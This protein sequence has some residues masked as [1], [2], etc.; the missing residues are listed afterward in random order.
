M[1]KEDTVNARHAL[2]RTHVHT[3]PV[4]QD[5]STTN[6]KKWQLAQ[7]KGAGGFKERMINVPVLIR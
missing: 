2:C 5:T 6:E 4:I 1:N 3:P 7:W